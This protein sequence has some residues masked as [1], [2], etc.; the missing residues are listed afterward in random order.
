MPARVLIS[1]EGRSGG[2]NVAELTVK[3]WRRA[4][5][6]RLYVN[7]AGP[8][9]QAVAW[10]DC[11][12]GV[13]TITDAA[14]ESSALDRV[15]EWCRTSGRAIPPLTVVHKISPPPRR[16]YPLAPPLRR[17]CCPLCRRSRSMTTSP[18]TALGKASEA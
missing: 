2:G 16:P 1:C 13:V 9:G 6:D 11:L 15:R 14:H 17:R 5:K 10:L 18:R 7:L 4:G 12:T 8:R 3:P